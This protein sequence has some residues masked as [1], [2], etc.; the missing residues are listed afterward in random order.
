MLRSGPLEYLACLA[1]K[2]HESIVRIDA[3]AAH[4]VLALGLIG[5]T[6]GAPARWDA[7]RG[8]F[9]PPDGDLVDVSFEWLDGARRLR[10]PA[11]AWLRESEYERTPFD[12]AWVFAGSVKLEDGSLAADRTGSGIALVNAGASLMALSRAHTDRDAD[13]WIEANTQAIPPL[14]TPLALLL[15]R[16]RPRPLAVR[17]DHRGDAYVNERYADPDDLADLLRLNRLAKTGRVQEITLD[18]ALRTDVARLERVLAS[19]GLGPDAIRWKVALSAA[20]TAP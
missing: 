12:R 10:S 9:T 1:G 20:G 5:L 18:R 15:E 8:V 6:P 14:Q 7:K 13:L 17:I 19:N 3:S 4:V 16:A 11:S 2:E